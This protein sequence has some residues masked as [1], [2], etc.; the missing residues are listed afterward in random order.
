MDVLFT[1]AEKVWREHKTLQATALA[2]ALDEWKH[3]IEAE[4]YAEHG[5]PTICNFSSALLQAQAVGGEHFQEIIKEV[6]V[7]IQGVIS[8]M[9]NMG[10]EFIWWRTVATEL[11]DPKFTIM[12]KLENFLD[13]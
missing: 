6:Q 4:I 8:D 7:M 5:L 12:K 13:N 10:L 11:K 1:T 2:D 9:E 3:G